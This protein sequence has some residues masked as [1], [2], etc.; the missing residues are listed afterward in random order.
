MTSS[1]SRKIIN[2][3][4]RD[5]RITDAI[6]IGS[7]ELPL[8]DLF[9]DIDTMVQGNTEVSVNLSA[10]CRMDLERKCIANNVDNEEDGHEI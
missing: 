7:P 4:W 9:Q 1:D 5:S 8:L 2:K 10:L 6:K 3:G